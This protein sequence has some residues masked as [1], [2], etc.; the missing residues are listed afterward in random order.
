VFGDRAGL[1][2]FLGLLAVLGLAL[3]LDYLV[4]DSATVLN[5]L[6]NLADGTLHFVQAPYGGVDVPG[7]HAVGGRQYGRNYGH[8]AFALPFLVLFRAG[9][10]L[11][12]VRVVGVL[13]WVAVTVGFLA[14][15]R[16]L[17]ARQW[18]VLAG[19]AA[20]GLLVVASV[21][22]W[23]STAKGDPVVL[24]LVT[25]SAVAG[26]FCGVFVYRLL[27]D[28]YGGGSP[29]LAGVA[30]VLVAPIGLWSITGKRHAVTT[31]LVLWSLYAFYRSRQYG[32]EDRLGPI[33]RR[34][35]ARAGAYVPV[36]LLAWVHAPEAV[37]LFLALVVVDLATAAR[38][39]P[40]TLA[41]VGGAFLAALLPALVTNWLVS[42]NPFKPPRLLPEFS[43]EGRSGGGEARRAVTEAGAGGADGTG[44]DGGSGDGYGVPGPVATVLNLA[45][46]YLDGLLLPFR[47][48]GQLFRIFVYT[49]DAFNGP[50]T[51][52]FRPGTNLSVFASAP[53]LGGLA[54]TVGV[55]LRRLREGMPGRRVLARVR[56]TQ[57]YALAATVV[58][59]VLY[60]PSLPV[61]V[62][63]TKRYLLPIYALLV[64]LLISVAVVRESLDAHRRRALAAF[65][66]TLLTVG[67]G[68]VVAGF[69]FE[70]D[71][72][73]IFRLHAALNLVGWTGLAVVGIRAGWRDERDGWLAVALG[74]TAGLGTAFVLTALFVYL[75]FGPS[76]LP[77]VETVTRWLWLRVV[78]R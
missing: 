18:P 65:L 36:G 4:N 20:T 7:D 55:A 27:A 30:A 33:E 73:G 28:E 16:G 76:L 44:S 19:G 71:L 77:A 26:A 24:A 12:P 68:V 31:V 59:V 69:L 22:V 40:R 29:L 72:G 39:D 34:T 78:F 10:L 13:A 58:F 42:G 41:V 57:W 1:A 17:L 51:P 21:L 46:R 50:V 45:E 9:A 61:R 3:R 11:V 6:V 32:S 63:L 25:S 43:P 2:L 8:A 74:V 53:L 5:V 14:V 47:K 15:A 75:H 23:P 49:G 37:T 35:V 70:S 64:F 48:P 52:P 56:P 62:Q 66:V 38:N 54:A 67:P 60:A